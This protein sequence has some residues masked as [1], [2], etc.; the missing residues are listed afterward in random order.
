MLL[1]RKLGK[2]YGERVVFRDLEFAVQPGTVAAVVGPNGA[3]KSTLLRMIAGLTRPSTGA[4]VW[5]DGSSETRNLQ[6]QCG[7]AA[8]DAPVYR[9]LTAGE[10]L[11]FFARTRGLASN[12]D[13]L[14]AHLEKFALRPRSRDLA[15]ALSSGLR[16]R[17]QL[18]I[19]TLHEPLIL[20][21][22]EPSANLDA[23]GRALLQQILE[24]QRRR[25]V[26]LVATNDPR[27]AGLCEMQIML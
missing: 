15:A 10:N 21:L 19:A 1:A 17:L 5:A 3:G 12:A 13:A 7:L 8:P 25:G 26:G 23:A 24:E 27:D 18:A 9:D 22:D 2:R 20:L 11:E 6:W 16:A 14:L 4:V